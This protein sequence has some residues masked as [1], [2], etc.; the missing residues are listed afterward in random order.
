MYS[1]QQILVI[2][3]GLEHELLINE[4]E[5]GWSSRVLNHIDRMLVVL[6]CNRLPLNTFL[7]VY[8]LL[9][10]EHVLIELLLQFLIGIVD[11]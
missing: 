7:L 3:S 1:C 9:L 8:I 5:D 6:E 4:L 11:A 10:S 2:A